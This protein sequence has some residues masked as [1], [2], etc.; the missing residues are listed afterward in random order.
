MEVGFIDVIDNTPLKKDDNVFIIPKQ[1]KDKRMTWIPLEQYYGTYTEGNGYID[2]TGTACTRQGDSILKL[3]CSISDIIYKFDEIKRIATIEPNAKVTK[4]IKDILATMEHNEN[5]P[6]LI[7]Q[8]PVDW[9]ASFGFKGISFYVGEDI[10]GVLHDGKYFYADYPFKK[11]SIGNFKYLD[12]KYK[13]GIPIEKDDYPEFVKNATKQAK[14][15]IQTNWDR[16]IR[17]NVTAAKNYIPSMKKLAPDYKNYLKVKPIIAK[18]K[19]EAPKEIVDLIVIGEKNQKNSYSAMIENAACSRA[20]ALKAVKER[21]AKKYFGSFEA[22]SDWKAIQGHLKSGLIE[23]IVYKSGEGLSWIYSPMVYDTVEEGEVFLGRVKVTINEKPIGGEG[24]YYI[25]LEMISYP[26]DD[27]NTYGTWHF[28]GNKTTASACIGQ[29]EVMITNN[30]Y[31]S[32][33]ASLIVVMH[34]YIQSANLNSKHCR[35]TWGNMRI[36]KPMVIDDSLNVWKKTQKKSKAKGVIKPGE[37]WHHD[38][39]DEMVETPAEQGRVRN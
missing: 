23:S 8:F 6:I 22:G 18:F 38:L 26:T 10:L 3:N 5:T 36:D 19:A 1:L 20:Y 15:L 27:G 29:Y 4:M 21:E 35:P 9:S 12:K 2:L 17:E 34:D 14:S 16:R 28:K 31:A 7:S 11:N 33:I 37:A 32:K 25:K 39:P 24:R 30:L 13:H